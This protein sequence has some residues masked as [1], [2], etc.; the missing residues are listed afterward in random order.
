MNCCGCYENICR[1]GEGELAWTASRLLSHVSHYW[2]NWFFMDSGSYT[3]AG[4]NPVG[5]GGTW[6]NPAGPGK[7]MKKSWPDSIFFF[8]NQILTIYNFFRITGKESA[9][10]GFKRKVQS[11]RENLSYTIFFKDAS[12]WEIPWL[13]FVNRSGRYG[14]DT[15]L[16]SGVHTGKQ[17]LHESWKT[18]GSG[19]F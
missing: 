2:G 4:Y 17:D 8:L 12:S 11:D 6:W 3:I 5:H 9:V 13:F 18:P 10:I 7:R 1:D 14:V 15:R 16:Y 19:Q